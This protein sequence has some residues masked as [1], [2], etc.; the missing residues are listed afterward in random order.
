MGLAELAKVVEL[1]STASTVVLP[2]NGRSAQPKALTLGPD[3]RRSK[4][5]RM[6]D[7]FP[8]VATMLADTVWMG[9]M[10]YKEW[11]EPNGS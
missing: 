1:L 7:T 4:Q 3:P 9:R 10:R 6:E 2:T 5:E 11:T 8:L